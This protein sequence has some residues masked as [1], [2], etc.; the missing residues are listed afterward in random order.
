MAQYIGNG[1][2]SIKADVDEC[3]RFFDGLGAS[4]KT[5]SKAIGTQVGQ[6]ARLAVRKY[7]PSILK[8]RTGKLYKSIYYKATSSKVVIGANADSG[9]HTARDGRIARYGYMLAAGY[10][11]QPKTIFKNGKKIERKGYT[12]EPRDFVERPVDRYMESGELKR[13]ID[14]AFDKQ[15]KKIEKKLGV[16]I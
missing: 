6:G 16:R 15:L 8:K 5:I 1:I 13:R 4:D 10:T 9:K 7:Y 11:I 12:V 2:I 3:L 14:N